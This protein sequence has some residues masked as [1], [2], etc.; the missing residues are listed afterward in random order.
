MNYSELEQFLEKTKDQLKES[1]DNVKV[2]RNMIIKNN[3][4]FNLDNSPA[5][6]NSLKFTLDLLC[7]AVAVQTECELRIK[8]IEI[9]MKN[10][11]VSR[12]EQPIVPPTKL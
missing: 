2:I 6:I 11:V 12:K 3:L 10:Y 8:D 4:D 1:N 7:E 9:E 5:I